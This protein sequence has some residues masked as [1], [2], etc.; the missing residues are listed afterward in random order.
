MEQ[1]PQKA[2]TILDDYWQKF[3]ILSRN[4]SPPM[5]Y[6][7]LERINDKKGIS[8]QAWSK[9]TLLHRGF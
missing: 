1:L 3:T 4:S 2:Y 7:F 8:K 5:A 6:I 9:R